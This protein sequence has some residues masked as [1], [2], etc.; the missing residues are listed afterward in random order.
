MPAGGSVALTLGDQAPD[1]LDADRAAFL[2][3]KRFVDEREVS[4]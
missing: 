1:Q 4:S 2:S 3:L